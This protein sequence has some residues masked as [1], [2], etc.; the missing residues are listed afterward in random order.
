MMKI[1]NSRSFFFIGVLIAL[2]FAAFSGAADVKTPARSADAEAVRAVMEGDCAE[3][4]AAWWGFDAADATRFLQAAIDS[5]VE[6]LV[7]PFMGAPWI[8]T[9]IR[10][11]SGIEIVFEPG[12][13][14][15]AKEGA[16]KGKG[17]SLFSATDA[18]DIALRGYGAVLRMRKKDYQSAAYEKAEWRMCLDFVGCSRIRVE[19]LRLESSGGDGIYVGA[20]KNQPYCEG[21][22]IRDVV[23]HDHH[24]Q[25]ISVI[26][27]SDLLIENCVLSGTEGTNPQAGIDFE[28]NHAEEKLE[29]CVVRNCI[30]EN[31]HGA[32]ILV[33][34]KPLSQESAPVSLR[35]EHCLV[36]GGA[37]T[38]IGIGAI[39]DDGPAGLIEFRNCTVEGA[40][41]GGLYLFDKSPERARVRFV[42]CAWKDAGAGSRD[43]PLRLAVRRPELAERVGGVDFVDCFVADSEDRAIL[44]IEPE[45]EP[46]RARDIRGR[47]TVHSPYAPS[48]ALGSHAAGV[49][50]EITP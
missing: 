50:L 22:V 5:P 36:R 3:A 19:G 18:T 38:G 32:G 14:V 47:I 40:A 42:D 4:S 25:G 46:C 37:D 17:D 31:N 11:R 20:T 10:L 49:A 2:H 1:M 33:Y 23:C 7:V 30:M 48:M 34:L 21:V 28:P 6:R 12:V 15:L 8:V 39:K 24:R 16:F 26:S 45:T 13:V 27:A 43:A 29:N 9:P 41:K 35:F 44:A